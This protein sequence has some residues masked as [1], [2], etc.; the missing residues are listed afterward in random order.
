MSETSAVRCEGWRRIGGAMSF[1]PPEWTQC[2]NNAVVMLDVVQD[3][4]REKLPA[5]QTCLQEALATRSVNVLAVES[6][7]SRPLSVE[8]LMRLVK[9]EG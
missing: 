7:D 8:E 6:L 5:C 1:G 2:E 4:K 9:E 3:K